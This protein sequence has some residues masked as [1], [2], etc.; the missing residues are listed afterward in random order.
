[1]V[2][3]A[4]I[5]YGCAHKPIVTEK[6]IN[7]MTSADLIYLG[8]IAPPIGS[9][10]HHNFARGSIRCSYV[11]SNLCSFTVS[12][13]TV[14]DPSPNDGYP[15]CI[16]CNSHP[17]LDYISAFEIKPPAIVSASDRTA[18]YWT[19][20]LPH[21]ATV[22]PWMDCTGGI[23]DKYKAATRGNFDIASAI[24]LPNG[25]GLCQFY[26]WY[27]T[28]AT[29]YPSAVW[30]T[31]N[32]IAP[33]VQGPYNWGPTGNDVYHVNKTGANLGLIP[34]AFSDAYLSGKG[35]Q[36]C[37]VG[38]NR[39]GSGG[40]KSSPGPTLYAFDCESRPGIAQP[41]P[42]TAVTP[43]LYYFQRQNAYDNEPLMPGHT[44]KDEC[45]DQ[46]WINYQNKRGVLASCVKGG[47]Y[48]WYGMPDPSTDPKAQRN[49]CLWNGGAPI[50]NSRVYG[51]TAGAD[52][53]TEW[54]AWGPSIAGKK[55]GGSKGYHAVYGEFPLYH[56]ELVFYDEDELREVAMGT[57]KPTNVH[58]NVI[59][60]NPP[61]LWSIGGNTAYGYG[62][63]AFDSTNGL[64]Y[65]MQRAGA[66][67]W[68][69][70]HVYQL[71]GGVGEQIQ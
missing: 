27:N 39:G 4:L 58:R 67:D 63:I 56:A 44:P 18:S 24:I 30:F 26:D 8:V 57:R 49:G 23:M 15:G 36:F 46:V 13:Q 29:D 40:Q 19:N 35:H 28:G 54:Y 5:A 51:K 12:G 52:C 17:D 43:L 53:S 1:M 33:N 66:G 64:L 60:D 70:M 7:S 2:L 10:L 37:F 32:P 6:R 62:G 59:L 65:L 61:E 31:P 20:S 55:D 21:G 69:V 25:D 16:I 38:Y 45:V 68:P 14:N 9:D 48:W 71:N 34:K 47:P 3:I 50:W 41:G 42:I 22:L 11:P